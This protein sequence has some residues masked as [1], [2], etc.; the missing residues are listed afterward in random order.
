M[1]GWGPLYLLLIMEVAVGRSTRF[2][3]SQFCSWQLLKS[4]PTHMRPQT[5][6]EGRNPCSG[7]WTGTPVSGKLW[8]PPRSPWCLRQASTLSSVEVRVR[9]TTDFSL[10]G[11]ATARSAEHSGQG[12]MCPRGSPLRINGVGPLFLRGR[13]ESQRQPESPPC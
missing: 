9:P 8:P 5:K 11:V 4:V 6:E 1:D 3:N 13:N 10:T 12:V 7:F 2:E